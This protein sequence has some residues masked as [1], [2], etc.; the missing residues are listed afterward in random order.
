MFNLLMTCVGG[1]LSPYTITCAKQST[2]H[3]VSVIGIDANPDAQGQYFSDYF[4][5]VPHTHDTAYIPKILNICEKH[6]INLILPG[7]D[8]EAL[9]LA[10]HASSFK[11][12]GTVIA[13][14]SF[15]TL[16]ILSNKSKTYEKLS[17]ITNINL[18][19][20]QELNNF[21]DLIDTAKR[22]LSDTGGVVLKPSVS[23]GGRDIIV[24]NEKYSSVY[25]VPNARE[26]RMNIQT[27]EQDYADFYSGKFPIIAMQQ[28][29]E[30]VFDIDILS[31]NG[32]TLQ[33]IPR[34]RVHSAAP[35]E[36]HIVV[37]DSK[38]INIAETVVKELNLSWLQDIDLMYSEDGTP[39]ILEINPR[40][41][42]S[43]SISVTAGFQLI[44]DLISLAKNENPS[45][46]IA[47]SPKRII[48]YKSLKVAKDQ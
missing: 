6:K 48:P 35:N 15:Q 44:D 8:E 7:S 30:P 45:A 27:F 40:P 16:E 2:K 36:G 13:C 21:N 29:S 3:E 12:L 4:Y 34:R 20:W 17:N 41:S 22:I 33:A 9:A 42:G 26:L 25:H 32:L 38:L 46:R 37:N 24:I 10:Y 31:M 47:P 43:F 5:C 1:G 23:R 28:L 39:Y 19:I 14:P 18:P 11:Q